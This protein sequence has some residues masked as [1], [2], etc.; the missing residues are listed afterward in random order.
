MD[1]TYIGTEESFTIKNHN[2]EEYQS[3]LKTLPEAQKC[4]KVK[5][6]LAMS[7]MAYSSY[8]ARYKSL[9]KNR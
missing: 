6:K 7:A 5:T 8:G 9:L 3:T 1:K 2:E 4:P